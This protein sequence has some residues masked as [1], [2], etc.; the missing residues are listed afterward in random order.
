MN[1]ENDGLKVNGPQFACEICSANN[2]Y[3]VDAE[4]EELLDFIFDDLSEAADA[5]GG[6][7]L[8][9]FDY[10]FICGQVCYQCAVKHYRK[11]G[12]LVT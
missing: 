6:T 12:I 10:S 1:S 9:D 5:E 2:K 11:K 8:D 4:V 7:V 3:N